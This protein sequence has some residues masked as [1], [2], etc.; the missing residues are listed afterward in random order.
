[1]R[2]EVSLI[3]SSAPDVIR[4]RHSGGIYTLVANC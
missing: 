3:V 2:V 1:M 4:A